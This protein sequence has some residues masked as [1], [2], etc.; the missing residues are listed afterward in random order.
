M[1]LTG[2]EFLHH[3]RELAPLPVLGVLGS[4]VSHSRSPEL[5]SL[6]Y[7]YLHV[8]AR[9][10]AV[11]IPLK[12]DL[13]GF[14][15]QAASLKNCRG[16]N[17]T[18][19]WKEA[20]MALSDP[21]PFSEKAGAVNTLINRDG[22]FFGTNTDWIGFLYP[23]REKSIN[24]VLILGW[25]G[26]AKGIAAGLEH[27]W[28]GCRIAAVSRRPDFSTPGVDWIQSDYT[29]FPEAAPVDLII[30]TT[31]LG[32]TGK[33]ENFSEKFLGQLP[34][35]RIAYDVIYTPQ[36]TAFLSFMKQKGA[37]PVNGLQ[38]FVVQAVQAHEAW[39]G[40]VAPDLK[41]SLIRFLTQTLSAR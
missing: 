13:P 25:G 21:D 22:R 23:I 37:E 30:N 15:S 35:T 19:P 31:P 28:P 16:F 8:G 26:A 1:V 20:V 24:S 33:T 12:E 36:E 4:P 9:Y 18:I 38:M 32:M 11:H 27:H 7:T 14:L 2:P 34:E 17:V 6:I 39:F 5:H 10:F 3:S 29:S 41:E 40:P